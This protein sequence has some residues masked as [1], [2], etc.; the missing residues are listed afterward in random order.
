MQQVTIER[1]GHHGDGLAGDLRA[2]FTLPGERVRGMPLAGR[3][4]GAE[5]LEASP[6]RVTPPCRH[7]GTC[8][9]CMLQHASDAFLAEWKRAVVVRA[10]AARGLSAQ[11]LPVATS[12]PRA[13]IRAVL[14]GRR[15]RSSVAVGFMGR[16]SA[17]LV[18]VGGCLLVHPDILAA[19]PALEAL[20]RCGAAR[21]GAVRLH[22][23]RSEAGPDVA[24]TEAKPLDADLRQTIAAI[25][26]EHDLARLAWNGE[27]IAERRPP[28]QRFAGLAVV[29][30]PSAFLQA[31]AE[32]A[33]ALIAAVQAAVG[34]SRR[35]ADLF[36]GCGTLALP[37]AAGMEV[38]AVEGDAELLG[39]LRAGARA[40]PGLH[41]VT[42]EAR[43]LFRRPL[44]PAELARFDAAVID[45]PRAGAEAQARALAA[46]GVARIAAVS[47][48][49]VTFAR[50]AQIL[51]AGG[52]SLGTVQVV[53]QFRWSGHVELVASFVRQAATP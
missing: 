40:S 8:G 51:V 27:L 2:A 21:G 48:N 49:P 44:L 45:P 16:R 18:E 20:T 7:F 38:H 11:M 31:T 3:L 12:P 6:H 14:T 28:V 24:V 34:G 19:R 23:T 43:D 26:A 39:A 10:L 41:R 9:G 13:R 22:V 30:P 36:A 53:D 47:C 25:A 50:D 52:Y 37:L 5:I 35:A 29:P 33:A 32:G 4:D 15:G 42:C 46:S 1:L 17:D